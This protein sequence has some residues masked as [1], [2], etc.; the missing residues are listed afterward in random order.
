MPLKTL[1]WWEQQFLDSLGYAAAYKCPI[2]FLTF[3]ACHHI[4]EPE[5]STLKEFFE[6]RSICCD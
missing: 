4:E 6:S 1:R 3:C 5:I 2:S